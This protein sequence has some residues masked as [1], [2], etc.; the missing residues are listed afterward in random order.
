MALFSLADDHGH[1]V[2]VA[3]AER[4][5]RLSRSILISLRSCAATEV[6]P[7][8]IKPVTTR[9]HMLW[10]VEYLLTQVVKHGLRAHPATWS[11]SC[12]PDLVGAR[13]LPG[14][15]LR[16]TDALPRYRRRD[17]HR[18]V[19]LEPR[20]IVPYSDTEIRLAGPARLVD[21]ASAAFCT[22]PELLGNGAD[23]VMVRRAVATVGFDV[24][25]TSNDVALVLDIAPRSARRLATRPLAPSVENAIRLRLRLEDLSGTHP[26]RSASI[27]KTLDH[28]EG[29]GYHPPAFAPEAWPSGRRQRS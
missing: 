27:S 12:F 25:L 14:L 28:L 16:L 5:A 19:G 13:I 11:G 18:A 2:L 22:G 10:L 21:A 17:A 3:D 15:Q 24:G 7:A 4:K 20:P 8:H 29:D 6:R 26:S 23:V 9:R 1:V